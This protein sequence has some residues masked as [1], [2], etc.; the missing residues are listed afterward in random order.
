MIQV[1]WLWVV[2]DMDRISSEN[3]ILKGISALLK[4]KERKVHRCYSVMKMWRKRNSWEKLNTNGIP[5]P[6]SRKKQI[7]GFKGTKQLQNHYL[8]RTKLSFQMCF[9]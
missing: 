5:I 8:S 3:S 2:L 9:I 7:K 4:S 1:G 6:V